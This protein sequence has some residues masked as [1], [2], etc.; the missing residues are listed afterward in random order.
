M[1]DNKLN[2]AM[3]CIYQGKKNKKLF[4]LPAIA[5][6][7]AVVVST[8]MVFLTKADEHGVKTVRHIK[9]GLNPISIHD[10]DFNTPHL[11]QIAKIG[12]IV[13]LV[14]LTVSH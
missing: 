5:P 6:L 14:A 10:L 13:A 9:G 11:G 2:L 4:W 12:L 8:L 7:I 3:T 1:L